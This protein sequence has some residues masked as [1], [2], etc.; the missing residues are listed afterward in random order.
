[1]QGLVKTLKKSIDLHLVPSA[2]MEKIVR[3]SYQ[4][5]EG[6]VKSFPHFVQQ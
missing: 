3:E 2:F 4:I 1:M 6:K 5:P